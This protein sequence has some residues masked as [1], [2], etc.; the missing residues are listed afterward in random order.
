MEVSPSD[1]GESSQ[2]KSWEGNGTNVFHSDVEECTDS[3]SDEESHC[4]L[5]QEVGESSSKPKIIDFVPLDEA[6][7]PFFQKDDTCPTTYDT[8]ERES[9]FQ[10]LTTAAASALEDTQPHKKGGSTTSLPSRT[11]GNRDS[12]SAAK[13]MF[14]ALSEANSLDV[15][16]RKSPSRNVSRIKKS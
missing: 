8:L 3:G 6:T 11:S 2:R 12:F 5:D 4:N 16:D 1:Q 13:K 15:A 14:E 9:A 7:K 10:V